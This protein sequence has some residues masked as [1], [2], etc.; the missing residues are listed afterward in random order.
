MSIP[1][2]RWRR[3]ALTSLAVNYRLAGSGGF[4]PDLDSTAYEHLKN[5]KH[6]TILLAVDPSNMAN[7]GLEVVEG[8]HKMD[9]PIDPK[10]NCIEPTWVKS[11]AWVPVQL[12]AGMYPCFQ[13]IHS[14]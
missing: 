1:T 6:L 4:S 8:S 3:R 5:I 11:Q 13:T 2:G 12:K 7:G 10:D 14:V 9:V